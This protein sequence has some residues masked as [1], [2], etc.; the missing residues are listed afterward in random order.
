M[1][2]EEGD[3]RA[4]EDG[5]QVQLLGCQVGGAATSLALTLKPFPPLYKIRDLEIPCGAEQQMQI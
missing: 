4:D 2:E 3:G 5:G 1:H